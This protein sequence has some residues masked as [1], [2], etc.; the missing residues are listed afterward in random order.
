ME[1][2]V[3]LEVYALELGLLSDGHFRKIYLSKGVSMRPF[4]LT[5]QIL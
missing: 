2:Y 5:A 4:S 1:L 3:E